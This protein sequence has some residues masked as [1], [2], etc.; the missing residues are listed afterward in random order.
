MC[1]YSEDFFLFGRDQGKQ[2]NK[3]RLEYRT[4]CARARVRVRRVIWLE[5]DSV[6]GFF[7][8]HGAPATKEVV[9]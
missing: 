6:L 2:K 4:S 9:Q 3:K 5:L 1:A 8:R 7:S